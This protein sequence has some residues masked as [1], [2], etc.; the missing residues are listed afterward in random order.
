MLEE[1][2]KARKGYFG[3]GV[4]ILHRVIKKDFTKKVTGERRFDRNERVRNKVS[5]ESAVPPRV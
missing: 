4:T 3:D 2:N 5:Q 1:K